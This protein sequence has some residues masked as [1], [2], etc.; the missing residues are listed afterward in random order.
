MA[1]SHFPKCVNLGV[2]LPIF[3]LPLRG[4][5]GPGLHGFA[6]GIWDASLYIRPFGNAVVLCLPLLITH[7]R[8]LGATEGRV[9]AYPVSACL[10]F[11][12]TVPCWPISTRARVPL[13]GWLAR[14]RNLY[15]PP[16]PARS[17]RFHRSRPEGLKSK[18]ARLRVHGI[19]DSYN[20]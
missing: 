13:I 12:L 7:A 11:A 10:R 9:E 3:V 15:I 14:M 19:N 20:F 2:A 17:V 5:A 16:A 18:R 6:W 1:V 4:R 8:D